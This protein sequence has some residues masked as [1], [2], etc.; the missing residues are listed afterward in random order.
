MIHMNVVPR[1]W[2]AFAA[3]LLAAVT[4]CRS[5]AHQQAGAPRFDGTRALEDV[6][7]LVAI[8]PRP[9][10]S[11]GAQK[12]RHYIQQQ[13]QRAGWHV[14]EQAFDAQTPIGTVRMVNMRATVP[15]RPSGERI[16]I[17]GHYDTKRFQQF[18]F[19]GAND[20]GSSTAFL[21]ELGR[22]LAPNR[23]SA[24]AVLEDP[25]G[26]ELLFLDGE[27][28]IIE[29]RGTDH[30]YGS[31]HYVQEARRSGDA[32]NIRALVLV[33]MIGDR[34]LRIARESQST[35]WLVDIIWSAAKR[36]QR[37]EFVDD[38]SAVDDD[39]LEFLSAGIPA[40]DIIDFDYPP[41]HT[42]QDTLDK[43]SA[44]SLQAVGDVV[45]Q[46]LPAIRRRV[47]NSR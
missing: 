37:P 13:L 26:L 44:D 42:A 12:A 32:T 3:C 15:N 46:A 28:A 31:R 35:P 21:L 47:A 18:T 17:A 40:V 2:R 20:A 16:V 29:W 22:A 5:A 8:G 38:S 27:E 39:H 41:W 36:L 9:A 45:L 25:I 11:S 19:V 4:A 1:R 6:R 33:D 7:Q 24:A 14:E 10:G 34:D 30:T 43:V 23:P